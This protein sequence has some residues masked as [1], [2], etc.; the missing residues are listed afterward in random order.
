M[1]ANNPIIVN[2]MY[3]DKNSTMSVPPFIKG[4]V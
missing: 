3:S 1:I 4:F 2:P